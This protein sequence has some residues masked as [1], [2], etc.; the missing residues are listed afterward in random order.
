MALL[1]VPRYITHNDVVARLNKTIVRYKGE[2]MYCD[3]PQELNGSMKVRL[4]DG[5]LDIPLNVHSSD[6]DLDLKAFPL[7]YFNRAGEAFYC[8]RVPVR[9]MKQC[10]C[11]ENTVLW[12]GTKGHIECSA[13][14]KDAFYS[15]TFLYMLRN[16]YPPVEAVI[17]ALGKNVNSMAFARRFCLASD[18]IG[19]I[20][21]F[22]FLTPVAVYSKK[23]KTFILMERFAHYKPILESYE[24]KVEI[25]E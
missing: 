15:K 7:G 8:T 1:A 2:F 5:G 25:G 16:E 21:L 9:K 20:K 4:H 23:Q 11:L 24:L 18:N 22:Y 6:E 13:L 3:C 12:Q 19:L 10:L 14:S 17:E